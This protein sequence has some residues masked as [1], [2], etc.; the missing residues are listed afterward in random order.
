MNLSEDSVNH[1]VGYQTENMEREHNDTKIYRSA[2]ILLFCILICPTS[3]QVGS[4]LVFKD[5]VSKLVSVWINDVSLLILTA[6]S[7]KICLELSD[8]VDAHQK[9]D[10][11]FKRYK[12]KP[13]K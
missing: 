12:E 6:V 7:I 10:V 5:T 4:I 9:V 2:R 13:K 3:L 8:R 11:V 1:Q